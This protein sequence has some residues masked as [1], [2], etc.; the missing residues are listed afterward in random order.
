VVLLKPSLHFNQPLH[1][2][3]SFLRKLAANNQ[4]TERAADG[5]LFFP[6]YPF[7]VYYAPTL[8]AKF[9]ADRSEYHSLK[10]MEH[11]IESRPKARKIEIVS[12]S[13]IDRLI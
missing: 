4:S 6:T 8:L 1:G 11:E 9:L 7:S 2:E 3:G 10:L 13:R 5:E 12:V